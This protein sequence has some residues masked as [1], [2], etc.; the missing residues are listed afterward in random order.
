MALAPVG[1][2][3]WSGVALLDDVGDGTTTVSL[4]V[5]E[6]PGVD[7]DADGA[8]FGPFASPLPSGPR[9]AFADPGVVAD[10]RAFEDDKD[11]PH[12]KKV[13]EEKVHEEKDHDEKHDDHHEGDDDEG[14]H[15]EG[16]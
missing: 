8:T 16:D 11:K 13:H 3:P 6:G 12:E 9:D 10:A 2:S 14:D 5:F 1:L 15:D 4:Y 7:T